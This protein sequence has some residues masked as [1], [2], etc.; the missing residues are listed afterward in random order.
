MVQQ[1]IDFDFAY[2]LGYNF[3]TTKLSN[4]SGSSFG[5]GRHFYEGYGNQYVS[6]SIYELMDHIYIILP[7]GIFAISTQLIRV[8]A[9][10]SLACITEAHSATV[11]IV[12]VNA[13]NIISRKKKESYSSVL[14][15]FLHL[16]DG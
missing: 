4:D 1:E 15:P 14:R 10:K 3:I 9:I 16:L 13:I 6:Y 5:S 12:A 2:P 7:S 8:G 11:R